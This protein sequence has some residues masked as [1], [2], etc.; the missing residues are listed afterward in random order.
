M[1][2]VSLLSRLLIPNTREVQSQPT[3]NLLVSAPHCWPRAQHSPTQSHL[4][5]KASEQTSK[6]THTLK[7]L[8]TRQQG[9][10][11]MQCSSGQLGT[12]SAAL[13]CRCSDPLALPCTLPPPTTSHPQNKMGTV[14]LTHCYSQLQPSCPSLTLALLTS[15]CPKRHGVWFWR[16]RYSLIALSHFQG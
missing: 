8:F 11:L 16:K 4:L 15:C 5:G 9:E 2:Q 10:P 14:L 12:A 3:E 13:C 7:G 6:P 1:F